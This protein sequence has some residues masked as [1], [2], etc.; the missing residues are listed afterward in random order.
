MKFKLSL[1]KIVKENYMWKKTVSFIRIHSMRGTDEKPRQ[2][3]M[4][5]TEKP[6]TG[7]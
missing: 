1:Q 5:N 7:P 6:G 3:I 2:S 4:S